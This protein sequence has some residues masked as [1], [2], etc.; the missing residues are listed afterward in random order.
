MV[1]PLHP[2]QRAIFVTDTRT[3]SDSH[4]QPPPRSTPANG[5]EPGMSGRSSGLLY[6]ILAAGGRDGSRNT[7]VSYYSYC[8]LVG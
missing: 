8:V 7:T 4:T 1:I 6:L 5:Y 2:L 3:L